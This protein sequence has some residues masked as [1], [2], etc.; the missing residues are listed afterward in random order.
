MMKFTLVHGSR[1]DTRL[2][3]REISC[4]VW[5]CEAV[6][7]E[8]MNEKGGDP[9]KMEKRKATEVME[10]KSGWGDEKERTEWSKVETKEWMG[11]DNC[12]KP[13]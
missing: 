5:P 3:W 7:S 1:K 11:T 10:R 2:Y 12:K 13:F 8:S 4:V 9:D 6:W